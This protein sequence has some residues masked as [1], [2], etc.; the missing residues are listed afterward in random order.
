MPKAGACTPEVHK[1]GLEISGPFRQRERERERERGAST[2]ACP[3]ALVPDGLG[4]QFFPSFRLSVG[5]L[6]GALLSNVIS[7]LN[8]SACVARP[9]RIFICPAFGINL[10]SRSRRRTN[11]R[12]LCCRR[13]AYLCDLRSRH[14]STFQCCRSL[15]SHNDSCRKTVTHI[16]SILYI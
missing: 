9:S 10:S 12:K 4:L 8:Y 3:G 5:L 6:V 1:V 7:S 11:E 13:V 16:R 15:W 14:S 2:C